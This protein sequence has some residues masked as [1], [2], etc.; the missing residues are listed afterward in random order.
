[1]SEEFYQG[2]FR[3]DWYAEINENVFTT[4]GNTMQEL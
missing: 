3:L 1:M 2:P 4:V